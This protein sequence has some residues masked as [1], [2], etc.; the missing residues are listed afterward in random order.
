MKKFPYVTIVLLVLS[1]AFTACKEKDK[2]IHVEGITLNKTSVLLYVGD[3]ALALS[4]TVL[5]R[6]ATDKSLNWN[7]SD[8]TIAVVDSNIVFAKF[9][10]ETTITVTTQDGNHSATC[11]IAVTMPGFGYYND[12]CNGDLPGWGA[13]TGA[14]SFVSDS[15]WTIGS[16]TWSDAVTTTSCREKTTYDGTK[17][18]YNHNA[19]YNGHNADCRSNPEQKGDLFS[20][21]AVIRFAT[22][23]CPSPWRV[24]TADDFRELDIALGGTGVNGGVELRDK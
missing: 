20:W 18:A 10:G 19:K 11:E 22:F 17:T 23:L 2:T 1:I 7:S 5:P 14:V 8:T 6:D 3:G 24:P 13:K 12:V 21:C 16:Q 4:A 15:V 9:P